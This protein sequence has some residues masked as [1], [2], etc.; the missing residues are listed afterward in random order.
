M[1][2]A[3]CVYADLQGHL[4]VQINAGVAFARSTMTRQTRGR[5]SGSNRRARLSVPGLSGPGGDSRRSTTRLHLA[6]TNLR[7]VL[8]VT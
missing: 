8:I 4:S 5:T 1:A 3:A 7:I 2:A 6:G